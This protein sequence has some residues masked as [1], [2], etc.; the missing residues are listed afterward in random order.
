MKILPAV[1]LILLAACSPFS[2]PIPLVAKHIIGSA[3]YLTQNAWDNSPW[4]RAGD[5][6]IQEPVYLIIADDY[7]AC[8]VDGDTFTAAINTSLQFPCPH[9]DWRMFRREG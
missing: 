4:H 2:R 1:F 5:D 9:N 3:E 6:F 7:T 8:A